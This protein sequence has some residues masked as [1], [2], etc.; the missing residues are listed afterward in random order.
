LFRAYRVG[1]ATA[2]APV[3]YLQLVWAGLM[4]VL[5]FG[6][7]LDLFTFLGAIL[8]VASTFYI[9]RISIA[10]VHEAS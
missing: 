4:G 6:E 8:I 2:I 1:E 3:D 5:I 9:L 7:S 10:R